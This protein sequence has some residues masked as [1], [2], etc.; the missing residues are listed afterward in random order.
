MR[1]ICPNCDAQYEVPVEVIPA[2]GRDVQCSSCGK[3]WFQ[4][5]PDAPPASEDALHDDGQASDADAPEAAVAATPAPDAAEG[6]ER[7]APVA[8]T[9]DAPAPVTEN[10]APEEPDAPAPVA[11]TG[12]RPR[13][14]NRRIDPDVAEVLRQEAEYEARHRAAEAGSLESQ[15]DLGLESPSEDEAAHRARQARERMARMRGE[16]V[17]ARDRARTA[18][19]STGAVGGTAVL[20]DPEDTPPQESQPGSRRDLLPDIDEINQTLRSSEER[21]PVETPQG[22]M[23]AEEEATAQRGGFSRGFLTVLLV[24]AALIAAY[25]FAP[26]ISDALP[27]AAEPLEGYVAAVND[28]R[29]WLDMQVTSALV[30]LETMGTEG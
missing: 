9:G 28:L 30:W 6:P 29:G 23:A 18:A 11:E 26:A 13:R 8:G 21:G 2:D 1:L 15:P 4:A 19:A 17:E 16:P 27:A 12:P 3:V 10:P 7:E 24:G 22:R 20:D 25:V 14:D 5:H